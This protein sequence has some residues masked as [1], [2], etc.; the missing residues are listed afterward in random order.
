[1][2]RQDFSL[3]NAAT[4]PINDSPAFL[5]TMKLLTASNQA[6]GLWSLPFRD[7]LRVLRTH[8]VS[9][10]AGPPDNQAL[11]AAALLEHRPVSSWTKRCCE[12]FSHTIFRQSGAGPLQRSNP[13]GL[14]DEL[15]RHLKEDGKMS[16]FDF[17]IQFS[18][19]TR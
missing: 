19:P 9:G 18:I 3:Q 2:G 5:A 7:K 1:M 14:Q 17:A 8:N 16:G 12:V 11:P 6:A 10:I 15:S 4:L 13:K